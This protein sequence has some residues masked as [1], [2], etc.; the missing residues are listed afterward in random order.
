MYGQGVGFSLT[1]GYTVAWHS[2]VSDK[3]EQDKIRQY[4]INLKL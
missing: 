1:E 4:L 2:M 3:Q